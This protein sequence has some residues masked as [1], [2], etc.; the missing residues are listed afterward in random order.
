MSSDQFATSKCFSQVLGNFSGIYSKG[1]AECSA[2]PMAVS[3]PF[4][5]MQAYYFL[6]FPGVLVPG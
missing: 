2:L 5:F 1:S 4:L 6:L 3:F